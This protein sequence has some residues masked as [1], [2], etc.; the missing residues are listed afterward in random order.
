MTEDEGSVA[1]TKKARRKRRPKIV[2]RR[3]SHQET[4]TMVRLAGA[5]KSAS[6]IARVVGGTTS[7][8]VCATLRRL[9]VSLVPK[10]PM[11]QGFVGVAHRHVVHMI[12][13]AA[14]QH[15]I[16]ATVLAGLALEF[17]MRSGKLE[18]IVAGFTTEVTA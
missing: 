17:A 6:Y 9:G 1:P 15:E 5:G 13:I 18:E 8:R 2:P 7:A 16:D 14:D 12:E 10:R 3:Y 11:E 4:V